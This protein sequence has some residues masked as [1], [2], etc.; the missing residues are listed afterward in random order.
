M[1]EP[2]PNCGHNRTTIAA[3]VDSVLWRCPTC[4]DSI[5]R[6]DPRAMLNREWQ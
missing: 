1:T 4:G 3:D 6:H 2:C 5:E